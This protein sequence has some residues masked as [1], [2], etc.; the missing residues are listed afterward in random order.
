MSRYHNF[1]AACPLVLLGI[2]LLL[3]PVIAVA[4]QSGSG[5]PDD[6][7]RQKIVGIPNIPDA[8][9]ILSERGIGTRGGPI[10]TGAVTSNT[11]VTASGQ[12]SE[13]GG[14]PIPPEHARIRVFTPPPDPAPPPVCVGVGGVCQLTAVGR[15][16]QGTVLES[17]RDPNNPNAPGGSLIIDITL[18]SAPG[19][20]GVP[21]RLNVHSTRV[22]RVLVAQRAVDNLWRNAPLPDIKL[23]INP[24]PG[25]VGMWHWFWVN[26][27]RGEPLAFPLHSD[28]PW[29]LYWQERVWTTSMQCDD[30]TCLTRHAVTTSHLED[31]SANYVDAIDVSVTL[32]PVEFVWDFG[33]GSKG[34]KPPPYNPVTGLGRAYTDAYTESPVKWFYEFD[35]RNVVG[36]FPVTLRGR[37]TGTY[38]ISSTSTF[39]GPY[40]ESGSLGGNRQGTWQARHV[41]CQVQTLLVAPGYVP[42]AVPCRDSRV[43]P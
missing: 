39:D 6:T 19:V 12:P 37:W 24:D 42:P 7:G 5:G 40:S 2:L 27:Y 10:R 3:L 4:Q 41:V 18:P 15:T 28:L 31:H 9:A 36:G 29:T 16:G 38:N 35:S 43:A 11:T 23:G 17:L 20:P 21:G 25:L 8:Q 26:N 32:T 22:D 34:S 14:P 30:A 13:S 1:V 33:D